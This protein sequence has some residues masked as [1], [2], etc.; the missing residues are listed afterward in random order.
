MD[1][2]ALED[3]SVLF[4]PPHLLL[5]HLLDS[6]GIVESRPPI[7]CLHSESEV[8]LDHVSIMI[9]VLVERFDRCR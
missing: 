3:V 4:V 5:D 1:Q 2:V 9:D 8:R 7:A 6:V